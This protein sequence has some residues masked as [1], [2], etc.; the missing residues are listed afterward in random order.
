MT[1]LEQ[2]DLDDD[3][4][5]DDEV[6]DAPTDLPIVTR[7]TA[8]VE[9]GCELSESSK[10]LCV[11][12]ANDTTHKYAHDTGDGQPINLEAEYATVYRKLLDVAD[13]RLNV[14]TSPASQTAAL[15]AATSVLN[16]IRSLRD[17]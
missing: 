13:D 10:S 6:D 7:W 4:V 14:E 1:T 15:I 8:C 5:D 3:E 12:C 17:Q 11:Q 9:C 2:P 16:S